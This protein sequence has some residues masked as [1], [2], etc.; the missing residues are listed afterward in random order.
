MYQLEGP[1]PRCL[2]LL[3]APEDPVAKSN[4]DARVR[5]AVR[6]LRQHELEDGESARRVAL[7]V[8]DAGLVSPR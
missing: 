3:L 5:L 8:K 7:R 4:P 6:L 2:C 1:A